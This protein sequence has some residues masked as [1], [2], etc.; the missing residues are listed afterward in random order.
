MSGGHWDYIQDRIDD[1]A[2]ELN[3]K[4]KS[5]EEKELGKLLKDLV[6]VIHSADYYYCGDY[7]FDSFE[8]S[9]NKFKGKWL[10]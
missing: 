6:E 1:I 3:P 4:S 7:G 5:K 2:D 9:W 10:K 8:K